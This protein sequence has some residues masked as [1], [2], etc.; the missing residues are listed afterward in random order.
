MNRYKITY[1]KPNR[2]S[3]LSVYGQPTV[4]YC[5]TTKELNIMVQLINEDKTITKGFYEDLTNNK[6]THIK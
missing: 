4:D 1:Y 2:E 3:W 6:I 5:K